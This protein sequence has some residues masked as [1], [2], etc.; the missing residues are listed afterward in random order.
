[1]SI[2]Q[3]NEKKALTFLK[4]Y[5]SDNKSKTLHPNKLMYKIL[6]VGDGPVIKEDSSPLVHCTEKDLD[7]DILFDTYT[8]NRPIR[9]NLEEAILGFKLGVSNMRVGEWREIIVHPELA[10]KKLGKTKPNQ[11]IIY[12]VTIIKE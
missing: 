11:L 6:K 8:S 12:D 10:Y 9:I 7:G 1:M 2:E 3:A 4:K 5:F